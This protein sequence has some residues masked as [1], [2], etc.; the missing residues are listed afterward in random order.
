MLHQ[1]SNSPYPNLNDL[2]QRHSHLDPLTCFLNRTIRSHH[3]APN[4][5]VR[6]QYWL[7]LDHQSRRYP[8]PTANYSLLSNSKDSG[9]NLDIQTAD[10]QAQTQYSDFNRCH[11]CLGTQNFPYYRLKPLWNN[12]GVLA[13][14]P[15]LSHGSLWQRTSHQSPLSNPTSTAAFQA[16]QTAQRP[17]RTPQ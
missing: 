15:D 11:S 8:F 17:L 1:K 2:D 12:H 7:H 3:R 14:A 13:V 10:N 6:T 5:F 4:T 9:E 16:R